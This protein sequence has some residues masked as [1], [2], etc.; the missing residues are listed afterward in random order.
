M[1]MDDESAAALAVCPVAD[2]VA[3]LNDRPH[4]CL[5]GI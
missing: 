3:G 5:A 1:V 2:V 4:T